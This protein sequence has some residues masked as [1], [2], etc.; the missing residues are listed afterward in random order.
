MIKLM[1]ANNNLS[2]F[3]GCPLPYPFGEY[4]GQ[5]YLIRLFYQPLCYTTDRE[6]VKISLSKSI[7]KAIV[8]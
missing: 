1:V 4:E 8:N 3:E 2:V 5:S 6:I 7:M